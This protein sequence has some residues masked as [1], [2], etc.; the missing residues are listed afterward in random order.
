[1][2]AENANTSSVTQQT[3]VYG[4]NNLTNIKTD[5]DFY[6]QMN[7]QSQQMVVDQNPLVVDGYLNQSQVY[8]TNHQYGNQN[9]DLQD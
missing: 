2:V 6:N 5:R 7:Y 4:N 1:M 3:S 9:Q 8:V